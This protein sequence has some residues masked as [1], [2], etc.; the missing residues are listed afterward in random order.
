MFIYETESENRVN[1][2][3]QVINIEPSVVH[4]HMGNDVYVSPIV[5]IEPMRRKFHKSLT[6]ALPLPGFGM[7]KFAKNHVKILFSIT[8]KSNHTMIKLL[9]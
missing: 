6:R 7:K 1:G 8:G 2:M 4:K 3:L 5:V 9:Y